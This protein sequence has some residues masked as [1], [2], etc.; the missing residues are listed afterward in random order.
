MKLLRHNYQQLLDHKAQE[1]IHHAVDGADRMKKLIMDLLEYSRIGTN[2]DVFRAV[3]MNLVIQEVAGF[4]Q[5]AG[6]ENELQLSCPVLPVIY[7]NKSQVVQLF[8]N[9]LGNALKYRGSSP[10]EI[11][12]K[13][14]EEL[15]HFLFS[16]TD[17]GIGIEERN[18]NKIFILFQRLHSKEEYSGTGIGLAT[19]KKIVELHGGSI[20]VES[21]PG[22]GSSFL[23]T[24]KKHS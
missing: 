5:K 1:Y 13:C 10:P 14:K 12:I 6:E 17:N 24:I 16:V 20:W 18:F 4:F 23:F 9:L 15:N 22:K 7:A 8:Q 21:T 11:V 2:K 19:C 3:D